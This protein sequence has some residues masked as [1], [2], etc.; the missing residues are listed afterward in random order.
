M[1]LIELVNNNFINSLINS[2]MNFVCLAEVSY[3]E[4]YNEKVKDLLIKNKKQT[5]LK[6]REHPKVGPYVQDLSKHLAQDYSDLEELMNR[7]N[8]HRTTASTSMNDQSSRSH[9]I[10]SISFSQ[11]MFN[12]LT[13]RETFSKINLVDLAGSERA[14]TSNT[15]TNNNRLVE[16]GHINKSLVT[17]GLVISTL[18]EMSSSN[19]KKSYIPYRDSILTWLLKD[20]LGTKIALSIN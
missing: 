10:F 7:G 20:S 3:L 9:A 14:N 1:Q 13:P 5:N 8:A 2:V 4:I 19:K 6:V 12:Q 17:L 11:A 15:L 16:G 18:A